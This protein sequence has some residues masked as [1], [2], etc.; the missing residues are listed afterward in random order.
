MGHVDAFGHAIIS[1][2]GDSDSSSHEAPTNVILGDTKSMNSIKQK[3]R[4]LLVFISLC[5]YFRDCWDI[6]RV[7]KFREDVKLI[8]CPLLHS[9]SDKLWWKLLFLQR[10]YKEFEVPSPRIRPLIQNEGKSV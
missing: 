10:R 7:F 4:D 6:G 5:K 8:Q 1:A 9:H 2:L 3:L